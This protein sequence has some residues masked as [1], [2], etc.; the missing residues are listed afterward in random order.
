MDTKT[1]VV[2]EEVW[3]QS[4]PYT[5]QGTVDKITKFY[6]EVAVPIT[7]VEAFRIGAS[8]PAWFIR[9]DAQGK[10]GSGFDNL[11]LWVEDHNAGRVP[12]GME[13]PGTE[14]GPWELVEGPSRIN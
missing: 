3:M 11:G 5:Q 10:A 4:G 14:Y 6:V 8:I 1:L 13:T 9:F 7:Q 12:W 2:G